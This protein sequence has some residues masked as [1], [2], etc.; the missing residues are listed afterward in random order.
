MFEWL[1]HIVDSAGYAGVF[2]LMVLENLFPPIPSEVIVPLAGYSAALGKF[3]VVILILVATFG[4]VVGALPWYY[5]GR[6]FGLGR[7]KKLAERY[8]RIVTMT[9][10]DVDEAHHV[11]KRY[12]ASA[13]LFG[14]LIPTVRTLI[15][16]PAGMA[17]MPLGPF[18]FFTT[19]GSAAWNTLLVGLGYLLKENYGLV[20]D[21]INPISTFVLIAIVVLYLY[22]VALFEEK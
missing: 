1:L 12:H 14:R 5:L 9:P 3:N 17:R 2:F 13:V 21:V 8:G 6:I 10:A 19:L 16:V 18:L 7:V 11:F 15:S 4:A 22:R 20:A